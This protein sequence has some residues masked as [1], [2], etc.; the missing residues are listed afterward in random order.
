MTQRNI[1]DCVC[2]DPSVKHLLSLR[3]V[4]NMV[5]AFVLLATWHHSV[6]RKMFDFLIVLANTFLFVL[7]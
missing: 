3:T 6:Q 2:F 5:T 7:Y 1:L 4:P